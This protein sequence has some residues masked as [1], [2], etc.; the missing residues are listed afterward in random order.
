[1]KTDLPFKRILLLLL[2]CPI[3][4]SFSYSQKDRTDIFSLLLDRIAKDHVNFVPSRTDV[5]VAKQLLLIDSAGAFIDVNYSDKNRTDWKPLTH[6]DRI[7]TIAEAFTDHR[8][9][10]Y[11]NVQLLHSITKLM[12]YWYFRDPRSDNWWFQKIA[13]CQ[14]MGI[15]L[16]IMRAGSIPLDHDTEK[17]WIERMTTMGGDPAARRGHGV[18]ANKIDI[19]M[20]CIYRGLLTCDSTVLLKGIEQAY[21]PLQMTDGEGF[22]YDYSYHQHGHQLYIGGYGSVVLNNVMK[23][24]KYLVNTGLV[25][26]GEKLNLLSNFVRNTYLPVVRGGYFLY[27]VSGRSLARPNALDASGVNPMLAIFKNIDTSYRSEYE[28]AQQRINGKMPPNYGLAPYHQHFH[29]S[30]YTIHQQ[31]DYTFDIRCASQRTLRSEIVNGENLLGYFLTDGANSINLT[32]KEYVDIFPLWDWS[33]IPGTTAPHLPAH[34]I[35]QTGTKKV[36]GYSR[37]T[38]GLTFNQNGIT[39]LNQNDKTKNIRLKVKKSWFCFDNMIVCMGTNITSQND[40]FPVLTTLDQSLYQNSI[41]VDEYLN[42]NN[43]FVYIPLNNANI[44]GNKPD[45]MIE[46]QMQDTATKI[47]HIHYIIHHKTGFYFPDSCHIILSTKEKTGNWQSVSPTLKTAKNR[48]FTLAINHG[49]A[50]QNAQYVYYI[51]PDTTHFDMSYINDIE[52]IENTPS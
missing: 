17:R 6:L 34:L 9:V 25:L 18:G 2:L 31:P 32:G 7:K 45:M 21:M 3:S 44:E 11:G 38:G 4:H 14:R 51:I 26:S 33:M 42:H 24:S 27:N 29:L 23:L 35:P 13:S 40:Q 48:V 1:M 20:H 37:F 12:D 28:N 41:S 47:R 50:P 8:S 39:V 19:A 43:D 46:Y 36:K 22:Q 10:Y 15:I 16:I 30:D 52:I 5:E 49:I